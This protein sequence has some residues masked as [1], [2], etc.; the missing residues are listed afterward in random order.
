MAETELRVAIIGAG[1]GGLSLGLA[2]RERGLTARVYEQAPE[3]TEIGA[4]IALSANSLREFD[5]LGLLDELAAESTIPTELIYRHWR[6]GSRISS[7][8]V[9]KDNAYVSRFGAPYFGIHRADIQTILSRAFGV[10]NLHL[11]CRIVNIVD[12]TDPVVLEF[13]NGRVGH[14]DIAVGADGVR[15]TVRRWV[16]GADDS[17][18]SGT[19]LSVASCLRTT[20]LRCPTRTPFSSGWDPMRT[21]C[22]MRSA[23]TGSR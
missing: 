22:T 20:S 12:E 10:E 15:S 2:L 1:M 3:L 4:A 6:D 7:H 19:A 9:R 18:Y 16:T 14:A 5:R 23:A 8:P 13:A 11:G 21:F 17:V